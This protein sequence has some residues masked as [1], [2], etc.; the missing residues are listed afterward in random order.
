QVP[1]V[2]A[3]HLDAVLPRPPRPHALAGDA[4]ER[5]Q[6]DRRRREDGDGVPAAREVG[7]QAGEV[8]LGPPQGRG[9]SGGEVGHAPRSRSLGN[10]ARGRGAIRY[11]ANDSGGGRRPPAWGG[12]QSMLAISKMAAAVQP[13]ATLA[14][15]AKA[16]QLKAEGVHV[17][18]FSL[19]E[20]DFL[21]PEHIC[22]AAVKAMRDGHT[23]YTPAV[24]I[25]ELRSA[26]SRWYQ[27]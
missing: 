11:N 20:P 7:A 17:F 22:Q 27:K 25:P 8:R 21:T 10:S 4:P 15:G 19:G 3:A 9:G 12:S 14:A 5:L 26:I 1:E 13:S 2:V 23:H 16:R 18:D 6:V 24:G